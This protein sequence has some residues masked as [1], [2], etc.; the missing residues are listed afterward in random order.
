VKGARS[1][2][3]AVDLARLAEY[4]AHFP[5]SHRSFVPMARSIAPPTADRPLAWQKVLTYRARCLKRAGYVSPV[6]RHRRLQPAGASAS[7]SAGHR[8]AP[9]PRTAEGRLLG[10]PRPVVPPVSCRSRM[11]AD[12]RLLTFN[13]RFVP[14]SAG[15]PR[16]TGPA[17]GSRPVVQ[18]VLG[19]GL[20]GRGGRE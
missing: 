11:A 2:T 8:Q 15:S 20:R 17:G 1:K 7:G 3:A 13:V 18:E 19:A 5:T 16:Q 9:P 6:P 4:L 12:G 10:W 14:T